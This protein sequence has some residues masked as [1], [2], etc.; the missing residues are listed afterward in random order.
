M[1]SKGDGNL[2]FPKHSK[3]MAKAI[4]VNHEKIEKSRI[5][6]YLGIVLSRYFLHFHMNLKETHFDELISK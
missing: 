1:Y 2:A 3:I 6:R 5:K 4:A